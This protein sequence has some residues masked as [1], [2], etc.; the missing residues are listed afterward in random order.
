MRYSAVCL[1][2]LSL[3][4]RA[5][6]AEE[7]LF[8]GCQR[9]EDVVY[10]RKFGT[11][12][13]MD[14]FTPKKDPRG[15]GVIFIVSGG[16]SS[17]HADIT[18]YAK[19]F[20]EQLAARGYTVFAVVHGSRPRYSIPEI[21]G[22]LERAVRYIRFHAK[23]FAI[24][25]DR[26][27]VAGASAGGHLALMIGNGAKGA[28][29]QAEDAVDRVSS[30]VQGVACL[31]PPTDFLNY[32]KAGEN[33]L[34]RGILQVFHSVFEFREI[35][36][37]GQTITPVSDPEKILEI[38]R[39]ISPVNHVTSDDPPTLLIHGDKDSVVPIQQ[40]QSII[41]KFQ[42][43]KVP[44][45]LIVRPGADHGWKDY[46]PDIK[47]IGDWFDAHLVKRD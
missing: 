34:G 31:C 43:A 47:E 4:A 41:E 27:G 2:L 26:I 21:I 7:S 39:N 23:D 14:V 29:P 46:T 11:A 42:A 35:D 5:A 36:S 19:P 16:W 13:T 28:N 25:P 45:K 1:L 40:S 12:L 9:R 15:V 38:G 30:R 8:P 17:R 33:A 3:T 18:T 22:D 10:G 6:V 44:C 37:R 32:G 24:D 20:I